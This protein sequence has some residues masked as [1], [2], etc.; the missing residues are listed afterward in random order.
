MCTYSIYSLEKWTALAALLPA[1][2]SIYFLT[3]GWLYGPVDPQGHFTGPS[4]TF[5]YPDLLTGLRGAFR[6]G[7]LEAA[8][9]VE[10]VAERC[11]HGLKELQ[12]VERG[13]GFRWP[14]ALSRSAGGPR[15]ARPTP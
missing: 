4:I 3:Q 5:L 15:P 13:E 11:R 10:V 1:Y 12:M 9:E 2:A 6:E 7:A 14:A 8:V